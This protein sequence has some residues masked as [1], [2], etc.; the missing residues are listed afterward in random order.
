M[1]QFSRRKI[2][3]DSGGTGQERAEAATERERR[4]SP[5][6]LL[7]RKPGSFRATLTYVESV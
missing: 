7:E 3:S 2:N 1:D 6:G 5:A 4:I